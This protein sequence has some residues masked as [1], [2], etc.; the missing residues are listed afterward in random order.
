MV[1]AGTNINI[2]PKQIAVTP[3]TAFRRAVAL[4]QR[5]DLAAAEKIYRAILKQYPRHFETLANLGNVLLLAERMEEAVRFLRRALSQ[6]SNSAIV[7]NLL[8]RTL[9]LLERYDEALERSRRAIVLDPQ[10]VEARATLAQGL[11]ELGRYDEARAALERAIELA[12]DQASLYYYWGQ[13]TRWTAGDPRIAALEGLLPRSDAL[14]LDERVNLHFALGK[15]Y[16]DCG[17]IERAFRHQIAG[18]TLQRRGLRY[19]E[20]ATLREM[21][22]LTRALDA[23]WIAQHEGLG[24]LSPRPVF[25]VGM[26]RSGTSLVEQILASHPRVKGLGERV[27]LTDAIAQICGTPGVPASL[28]QQLVHWSGSELRRL[29]GLYLKASR[30][31]VPTSAERITDKLPANFR[32]A[33]LIHAALPNA[34][35]IHTVRDPV[36]TCLSI[37]SILFSGMSQLYS[38]DLGELGRYYRAYEKVMAH[39]RRVL[40]PCVMLEVRYEDVVRDLAGQARRI[41]GHCGL[42]WDPA[43]L[44]FH[45]AERPVRTISHAQVRQPIYHSSVGRPRPPRELML[46]LLKALA[47]A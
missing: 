31:G 36:D 32:F 8:A 47:I 40:P 30:R 24:D 14:P 39:W 20:A 13:I 21:D 29:G 23:E 46:P 34:R 10:L 25:I 44:D 19:N 15:A 41:V 11:A 9:Q 27:T 43:C 37:F 18:G 16:A 1:V 6:N 5:G 22:E 2:A 33:G 17:E 38:Y 7:H 35:I 28:P 26:A 4:Q 3:D 12:P 45:K 42:E